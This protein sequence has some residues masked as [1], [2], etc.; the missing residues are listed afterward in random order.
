MTRMRLLLA[1]SVPVG[2]RAR[3]LGDEPVQDVHHALASRRRRPARP[4]Q[5]RVG[6]VSA[7]LKAQKLAQQ[8]TQNHRDGSG[9]RGYGHYRSR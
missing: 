2:E 6:M 3:Q 4:V 7:R 9:V 1:A 5:S 8:R